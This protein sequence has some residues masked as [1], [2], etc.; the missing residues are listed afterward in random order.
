MKADVSTLEGA[1]VAVE[2]AS[3]VYHAAQP[4]HTRWP[5]EFPQM[6]DAI[7]EA[8]AAAGA[9]LVFADNLYM[10][11]PTDSPMTEETPQRATGKKGRTRLLIAG[12]LLEAHRS[13]RARVA[14]GRSSDYYGPRGT[15]S[16][17]GETVFGAAVEGKTVRWPAS[18]EVP[19]QF[20][21]LPD[22]ARPGRA[23]RARGGRRRG[24]AP[25]RRR[26]HHG[27]PV[28]GSPLRRDQHH[29]EG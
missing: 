2:G 9:K 15:A 23:G 28:L 29:A 19:H 20:N 25:A 3:V 8:A 26:A 11:G 17:V 22:M 4:P 14:I 18:L 10:Y 12:R 6:T 13:G 24:L 16:V 21:Y 5:E 7:V 27:P 1:R